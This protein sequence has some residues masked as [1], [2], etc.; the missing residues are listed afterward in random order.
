MEGNFTL[1][2]GG[3][4]LQLLPDHA[5]WC[6][7]LATV[8]VADL[9]LGKEQTFRRAGIPIPD[10]LAED[11]SRL[12]HLLRVTAPRRLYLL[13]DLMHARAGRSARLDEAFTN[14]RQEHRS[15]AM[16]LVRGN[17]DQQAGDPPAN[18]EL[19]CV[20]EPVESSPFTLTHHPLFDGHTFNLAGH[21]HPKWRARSRADVLQLPCFLLR[22]RSLVLPAFGRFIDH[23]VIAPQAADQ[24]VVV[25]DGHCRPLPG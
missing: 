3:V 24:I 8:W 5:V 21:L 20:D 7:A 1:S 9:H 18:W 12:T 16:T 6:P 14:W 2:F 10:L 4:D 15:V 11:L 13:G 22:Q 25:A 19:G 23:G 17:H